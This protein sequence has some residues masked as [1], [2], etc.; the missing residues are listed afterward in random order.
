MP[1]R[2]TQRATKQAG[3]ERHTQRGIVV[4]R[5]NL[6]RRPSNSRL[7][8]NHPEQTYQVRD[9]GP[10]TRGLDA[11]NPPAR[12][13]SAAAGLPPVDQRKTAADRLSAA[14]LS[15]IGPQLRSQSLVGAS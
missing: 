2:P 9:T 13:L 5:R 8:A 1:R 6:P 15:L 10:E 4:N 12:P 3:E 11:M 7:L 14:E